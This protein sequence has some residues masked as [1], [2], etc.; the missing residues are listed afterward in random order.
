M[1]NILNISKAE[2]SSKMVSKFVRRSIPIQLSIICLS[3]NFASAQYSKYPMGMCNTSQAT[4]TSEQAQKT[5]KGSKILDEE[6]YSDLKQLGIAED[7]IKEYIKTLNEKNLNSSLTRTE[8]ISLHAYSDSA[9]KE[10]NKALRACTSDLAELRLII[11]TI[12]SALAKLPDYVGKVYRKTNIPPEVLE[13]YFPGKIIED[14]GFVSASLEINNEIHAPH[15]FTILSLHGKLISDFSLYD[16]EKEVLF[17]NSTRFRITD[18][19]EIKCESNNQVCF[20]ITMQEL[21]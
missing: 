12:N 9:Y 5:N 3:I 6:F 1:H 13:N 16:Y 17:S 7:R 2:W 15:L 18:R 20:H 21:E 14:A 11:A 10:I 4:K 19:Q 8:S